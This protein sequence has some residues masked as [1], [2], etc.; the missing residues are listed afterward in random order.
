MTVNTGTGIGF[1]VTPVDYAQFF[2]DRLAAKSVGLA[3]GFTVIATDKKSIS[4]PKVTADPSAG[5]VAEGEA[6]P[7]SETSGE[8]LTATPRKLGVIEGLTREVIQDSEPAALAIAENSI[9]R[10]LA[11]KLD[12]GFFEGSGTAPEPKGLKNVSGIQTI[13]LGT[14]GESLSNL[15]PFAEALGMLEAENAEG[16]AIVMNPRT[17]KGLTKLKELTS[18]SNKPLLQESAGSGSQGIERTIYNIPVYLSSQLSTT[19]TQGTSSLASSIYVYDAGQIVAVRRQNT[20]V[21]VFPQWKF[22]EDIQGVRATS[23]WDVA[24]PNPKAVVRIKGAL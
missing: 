24:V 12:L 11:L 16:S 14:N 22:R 8:T 13:S 20:Q 2:F 1:A 10:A 7:E 5:W 6:L 9:I 18:G 23:R 3:S 19:E 21:D 4:V 17:W 15:D